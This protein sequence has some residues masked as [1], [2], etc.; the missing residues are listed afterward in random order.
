VG[1][2]EAK[3]IPSNTSSASLILLLLLSLSKEL[4]REGGNPQLLVP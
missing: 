1:E 3:S 2:R 4:K